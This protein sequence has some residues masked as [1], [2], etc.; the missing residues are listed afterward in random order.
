MV[1]NSIIVGSLTIII[2]LISDYYNKR[3][4]RKIFP[5]F[6]K[7][8]VFTDKK[9]GELKNLIRL[10]MLHNDKTTYY[11]LQKEYSE[12]YNQVLYIK[13]IV[14]SIFFVPIFLFTI[15][16]SLLYNYYPTFIHPISLVMLITAIYF[17][18]KLTISLNKA[19]K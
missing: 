13:I 10:T 12:H 2:L 17:L 15:I 19:R 6:Q 3:L 8:I 1:Q 4:I 16:S 7:K 14:N 5:V 18:I 11:K 9:L